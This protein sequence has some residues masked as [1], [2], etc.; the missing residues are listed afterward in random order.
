MSKTQDERK[1]M[2]MTP[3]ASA[4]RSIMFVVQCTR[5]DISYALRVVSKYQ[6][7]LGEGHKVAVKKILKYLRIT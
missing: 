3:Y 1:N 7:D 6:F 2:S 5:L 4:I